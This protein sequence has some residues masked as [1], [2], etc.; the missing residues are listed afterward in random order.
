M[1]NWL[2]KKGKKICKKGDDRREGKWLGYHRIKIGEMR[3]IVKVNKEN[4]YI[5]VDMVDLRKDVY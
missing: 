2:F 1:A 3:I 5:I 4:N